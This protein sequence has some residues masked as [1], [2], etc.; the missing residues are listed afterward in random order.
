MLTQKDIASTSDSMCAKAHKYGIIVSAKL[1]KG[2]KNE[3]NI[4]YTY[5]GNNLL[6]R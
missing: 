1:M 5:R 3:T 4:T 2:N 6:L